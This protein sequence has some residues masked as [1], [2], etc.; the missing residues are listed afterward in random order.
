MWKDMQACGMALYKQGYCTK[1]SER[2][3]IVLFR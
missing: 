3:S 1:F 2:E